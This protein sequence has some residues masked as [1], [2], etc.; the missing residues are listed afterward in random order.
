M[1]RENLISVIDNTS[2]IIVGSESSSSEAANGTIS[3]YPFSLNPITSISHVLDN[4]K[5]I[6]ELELLRVAGKVL[7]CRRTDS[8]IVLTISDQSG[9]IQICLYKNYIGEQMYKRAMKVDAEDVIRIDGARFISDTGD[10]SIKA[11]R[12]QILSKAKR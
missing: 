10:R 12:M 11:D 9:D 1:E 3:L 6:T 7:Q 8:H 2:E 4:F 5:N